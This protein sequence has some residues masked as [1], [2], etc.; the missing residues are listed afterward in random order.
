MRCGEERMSNDKPIT[1][2]INTT[3]YP[4]RWIAVVRGR[5]VGVGLTQAQAHRAA[6]H[7]RGKDKPQLF[8]VDAAGNITP[9]ENW[10]ES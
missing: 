6:M 4:N 9:A 2:Q 5:V 10:R 3:L 1:S 7:T 8:F